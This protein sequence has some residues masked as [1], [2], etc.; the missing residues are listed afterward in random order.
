[1]I[2][3]KTPEMLRKSVQPG[4]SLP[5]WPCNSR[6]FLVTL[7]MLPQ[8]KNHNHFGGISRILS[9]FN[10]TIIGGSLVV[11]YHSLVKHALLENPR[12][13][14]DFHTKIMFRLF[15]F[16]PPFCGFSRPAMDVTSPKGKSMTILFLSR[17]HTPSKPDILDH[18]PNNKP[19]HSPIVVIFTITDFM[20][21]I[22]I[23]LPIITILI[24]LPIIPSGELT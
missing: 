3:E 18:S 11:L 20:V 7:V 17:Y 14:V 5:H 16:G 2:L 10:K 6:V 21:T 19:C 9:H 1:M 23:L 12:F 4:A 24:L 22:L 13:I 8:G 15:S